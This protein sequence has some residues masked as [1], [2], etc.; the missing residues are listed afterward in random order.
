M[1][2]FM[3]V[4]MHVY[5]DVCMYM[6]SMTHGHMC[7]HVGLLSHGDS[8]YECMVTIFDYEKAVS[9]FHQIARLCVCADGHQMCQCVCL[10]VLVVQEILH[11]CTAE[12]TSV[13]TLPRRYFYA[14]QPR[15][16][17]SMW[18]PPSGHLWAVSAIQTPPCRRC[19]RSAARASPRRRLCAGA[20]TGK[21]IQTSLC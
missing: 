17:I 12:Q 21:P 4:Y 9:A 16:N 13:Q 1:Y 7:E 20:C 18:A 19:V 11:R 3:D 2:A 8:F 10:H 14:G 5:V 15:T 6:Y